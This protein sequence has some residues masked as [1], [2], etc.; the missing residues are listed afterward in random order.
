MLNRDKV[1]ESLRNEIFT[2]E[3]G[4]LTSVKEVEQHIVHIFG[5]GQ[6]EGENIN[7]NVGCTRDLAIHGLNATN[8]QVLN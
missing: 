3:S 1:S 8:I 5:I 4:S 7:P 6:A 2:V